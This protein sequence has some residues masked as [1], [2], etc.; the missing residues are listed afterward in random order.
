VQFY[1]NGSPTGI[2]NGV[3]VTAAPYTAT[4][5]PTTPGSY[6][7]DAIA[8]DDRGNT[9]V[10]NSS[11]ITASFATPTVAFTSPNPN[12]VARATPNVPLTLSATATVQGGA[13]AAVLLVEFLLD[14]VQIGARTAPNTVNGNLYSFSWLP[15]A[16]NL[17][18]HVLTARV[19]DTNSQVSTSAPV[20]VNVANVVGSPPTVSVVASPIPALFGLQTASTVNFLATAV[21]TGTGSTLSNVEIFLNDLSIGLAAREQNTNLYRLAFDLNRFDFTALTPTINDVTGAVTYPVRL[22]AIAR[23]S[24]NN[25]TVSATTNL[26]INPATSTAPSIQLQA[27]TPTTITAGTQFFMAPNI[28]DLDGVV[29]SIQLYANGTPVGGPVLNP[30]QGQLLVYTANNAGGS[31]CSRSPRT[32]PATPRSRRRRS[33]SMSPPSALRQPRSRGRPTTRRPPWHRPFSSRARRS[34]PRRPKSP[35]CNSSPLPPV[36][37]DR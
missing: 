7:I 32:I 12:A 20:T 6:V 28:N 26:V 35:R 10:S 37:R 34:I 27:L 11:T 24:N 18:Q 31:T 21:A 19:T 25:Q 23:D 5:T 17:G 15:T 4:F 8:T 22:Y 1:V 30:Q 9:T 33:W 36:V 14:G 2:N 3:A 13:G 16:A 29:T